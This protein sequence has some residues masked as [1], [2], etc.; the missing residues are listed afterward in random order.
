M[1]HACPRGAEPIPPGARA[2]AALTRRRP[3]ASGV[4]PALWAHRTSAP[5]APRAAGGGGLTARACLRTRGHVPGGPPYSR[6]GAPALRRCRS[7]VC[8]RCPA[9]VSSRRFIRRPAATTRGGLERT[10]VVARWCHGARRHPTRGSRSRRPA[11]PAWRCQHVRS[12]DGPRRHSGRPVGRTPGVPPTHSGR[13]AD[14][15]PGV[16]P[17]APRRSPRPPA[18]APRRRGDTGVPSRL[19]AVCCHRGTAV[20]RHG[21]AA[22]RRRRL[23]GG[24]PPGWRGG[25]PGRP[26]P[27]RGAGDGAAPG[28]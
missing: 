16:P 6:A 27:R 7:G 11:A 17:T 5:P 15:T 2:L 4:P 22:F 9:V 3:R 19:A 10:A 24:V 8:H 18:S 28:R 21:V 14:R 1:P 20:G 25:G 13:A 12:R 23:T 26:L